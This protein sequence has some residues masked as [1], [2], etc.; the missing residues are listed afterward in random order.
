VAETALAQADEVFRG[1]VVRAVDDAQG[2]AAA[3][4]QGW[5]DKAASPAGEEVGR[6]HYHA[7]ASGGGQLLPPADGGVA[8]RIVRKIGAEL[9][10]PGEE[11]GVGGVEAGR[12][13]HVP[14]VAAVDE[15]GPS[16]ARKRK[17]ARSKASSPPHAPEY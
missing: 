1:V 3:A 10:G 4:F 12:R 7:L 16:S 14:S 15:E 11:H 8:L 9:A 5:L 17:G 13:F 2:I 6:L